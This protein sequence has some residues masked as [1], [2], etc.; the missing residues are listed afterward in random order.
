MTEILALIAGGIVL[1]LLARQTRVPYPIALVLGGLAVS[2]IPGLP[3]IAVD[4]ELALTLVLPPILYQAAIFT[5]WR[6]FRANIKPIGLLAI[7]LVLVTTLGVAAV[8]KLIVPA[9]PWTA[10]LVLGAIVSPSD[11]VAATAIMRNVRVPRRIVTVIEG[12]SLVNDAAGLV[13]FRFALAA[14][15]A[16]AWSFSFPGPGLQFLFLATGG[17]V[18]GAAAGYLSVHVQRRIADPMSEIAFS[19]VFPFAVFIAAEKL[20]V[21]AVLAVVAAGLVRG[22]H[23]PEVFSAQ[24]R[25]QAYAVWDVIVFLINTV[26]FILIGLMLPQVMEGLAGYPLSTLALCAVVV[27]AAVIALRFLVVFGAAYGREIAVPTLRRRA[28]ELPWRHLVIV[29]WSGMRGVVSL[30]MALALPLTMHDGEPFPQ[31]ELILFLTYAVILATLVL[32]GGTL[33]FVIRRLGV[34]ADC[35]TDAEERLA[36][37]KSIHAAMAEIDEMAKSG[38]VPAEVAHTIRDGYGH[39]LADVEAL[40]GD[41]LQRPSGAAAGAYHAAHLAA[42]GAARRRLIKLRRDGQ[43][44]DEA[45][46]R[47]QRELDLEEVRL[48]S[49]GVAG[50]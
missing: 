17:T 18:I 12:E 15:L 34:G 8:A 29:G 7:G 50:A 23:A 49:I 21:S 25:I 14:A 11:A 36:R 32:Q 3:A 9:M 31:R 46:Q 33:G 27:S 4:P 22:W 47:L 37:A 45:W 1:G 40:F 39:R 19:L 35:D 41:F 2:F 38:R 48:A 13:F 6:D 43:I 16:G 26:V 44:G 42:L 24:T 20:H 30:V 28:S 10:A 5:S